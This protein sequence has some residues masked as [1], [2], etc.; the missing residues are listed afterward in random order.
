MNMH[1]CS[2]VCTVFFVCLTEAI[3]KHL[4][5]SR[6]GFNFCI[7]MSQ[8][9][10]L[11]DG[12]LRRKSYIHVNNTF[13]PFCYIGQLRVYCEWKCNLFQLGH[14]NGAISKRC[15]DS[16]KQAAHILFH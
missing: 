5:H 9:Q 13:L 10:H 16:S 8:P 11:S 12:E 4:P 7:I 14:L 1:D 2:D 6:N 15:Y 3:Q